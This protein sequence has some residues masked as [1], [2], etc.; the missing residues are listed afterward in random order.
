MSLNQI[1][2]LYQNQF[3]N[4]GWSIQGYKIPTYNKY[5][6]SQKQLVG[7]KEL[8]DKKDK[9]YIGTIVTRAK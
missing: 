3:A 6:K 7:Y 8:N 4:D 2:H 9:T 5:N 1:S